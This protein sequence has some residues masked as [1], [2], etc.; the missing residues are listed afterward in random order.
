MAQQQANRY[1]LQPDDSHYDEEREASKLDPTSYEAYQQQTQQ[2]YAQ[3]QQKQMQQK[4]KQFANTGA[5]GQTNK[6]PYNAQPTAN[7]E[8]NAKNAAQDRNSNKSSKGFFSKLG[9]C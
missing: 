8:Q 6:Y 2:K 7:D 3:Q 5:N 1:Q 4:S 9:C